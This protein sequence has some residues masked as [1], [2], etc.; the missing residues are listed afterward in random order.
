MT[1]S[2]GRSVGQLVEH[3][4]R[5]VGRAVVDDDHLDVVDQR[6]QRVVHVVDQAADGG[7]VVVAREH[8]RDAGDR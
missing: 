3:R 1:R 5:A 8:R 6:R 4:A 7:R 2:H